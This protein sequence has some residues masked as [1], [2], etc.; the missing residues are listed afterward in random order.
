M[1]VN[2]D[3]EV[4]AINIQRAAVL[5]D[6]IQ[7]A[8]EKQVPVSIYHDPTTRRFEYIESQFAA[9]LPVVQ[10]VSPHFQPPA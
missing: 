9:G 8:K 5:K 3:Q 6:A 1:C 2:C 10:T 4:Q 7:H